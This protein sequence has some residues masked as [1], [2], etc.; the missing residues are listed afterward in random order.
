[1]TTA[2]VLWASLERRRGA[3]GLAVGVVQQRLDASHVFGA[4]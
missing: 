1:V 3:R 2:V 4:S